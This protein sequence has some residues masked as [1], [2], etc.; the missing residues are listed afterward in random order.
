LPVIT[1]V[2]AGFFFNDRAAGYRSLVAT[3]KRRT[4]PDRTPN[5]IAKG[6]CI[7]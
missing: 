3:K 2:L 1:A 6:A 5:P 7:P 4:Y